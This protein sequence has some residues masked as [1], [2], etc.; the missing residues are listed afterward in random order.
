VAGNDIVVSAGLKSGDIVVTAGAHQLKEGQKVKLLSETTSIAA[1][2][3][4]T[5]LK[6]DV[7]KRG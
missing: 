6:T 3:G 2:V 1:P 5:P 7:A 4:S